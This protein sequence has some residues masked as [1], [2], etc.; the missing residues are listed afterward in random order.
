MLDGRLEKYLFDEYKYCI[1]QLAAKL[2]FQALFRDELR[3]LAL[4]LTAH[5]RHSFEGEM[6]RIASSKKEIFLNFEKMQ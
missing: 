2:F 5:P 3:L 6:S 1:V 4:H